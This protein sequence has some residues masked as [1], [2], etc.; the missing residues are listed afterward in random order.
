[1][2]IYIPNILK[3]KKD[4]FSLVLKDTYIFEIFKPLSSIIRYYMSIY[5]PDA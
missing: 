2:T 1:M 3:Y 5:C 4:F